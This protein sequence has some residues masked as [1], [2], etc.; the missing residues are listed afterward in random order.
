LIGEAALAMRMECTPEELGSL[1]HP[2][3]TISEA[4]MEAARAVTKKAI[5]I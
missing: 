1:M 3:P 2:H 4:L 5:Q